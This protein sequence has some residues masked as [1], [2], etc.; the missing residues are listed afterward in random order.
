MHD[1]T[2][3]RIGSHWFKVGALVLLAVALD[4]VGPA[5]AADTQLTVDYSFERPQ[6]S[7]VT[8]GGEL[9]DRITMPGV[10]NCGNTGEPALPA[11][12]ARILLPLGTE[13]SGIELV[14]GEKVLLGTDYRIEPVARPVK[15]S[16][17][18]GS[19]TLPIPDPAIYASDQAFPGTW[20]K[21]IGTHGF[22]GYRILTLK[23]QPVQYVPKSGELCYYPRLT[24]VVSIADTGTSPSL[25]RG[26]AVD[27][28]EVL[29]KVDNI[30]IAGTYPLAGERG[31]S[32]SYDLLIITT[33]SL[34]SAFQ[35][36]KD[37]HDAHGI[38]TEIHTTTEIGGSDP[39]TVRDYITDRYNN[40]G[41]SYVI[42][43][44]DDDLIP[45]PDLYVEAWSGGDVESAMPGDIYFA[46]LDGTWNYDGDSSWGEPNDG[47]GGGDVD[48]VAEV[49]VGRAS[50]GNTTEI[51][52]FV[53]KTLWYLNGGHTQ[54]EKVLLVGE[55]LGFGGVSDYAAGMMEQLI[56][57]CSADGYTTVGIPSSLYTVDELFE[58][59]MSWSQADIINR[60]D[61]GVHI[62]NHLGHGS[63]D[64]AMK[65]YDSDISSLSNTD[66]CF[67]YS[68][69]CLAGHFDGTDCWAEYMNLKT[70]NG[71]YAVIMNAR[72]GWGSGYSTDGPNQR[73]NR[74]FWDAVFGEGKMELG[75][76]NHDSKEDNLYRVNQECM[77]WCYYEINL[78]GDPTVAVKGVDVP[79][80]ISF[81]SGLPGALTPGVP[82]N[83]SVQIDEGDESYVPGSGTLYYRYDGGTYLT[84]SLVHQSGDLYLA[85]LPSAGCD[86]TPEFYFSAEGS[87]SGVVYS[88][89]GGAGAPYTAGVGE[90]IIVFEDDCEADEGW[91]VTGDASD[92]QWD[93]GIPVDCDRGDPPT[94]YD[95][96]GQC[97]LTD[98]S[99]ADSCN[100]DVDG[101]YTYLSS[102]TF[103][104]SDGDA[105]ISYALWYTNDYG[106]DPDNDLFKV[107]VS[108][109]NGGSWTL[110]ETFGPASSSGWTEH[111]FNV[112]DFVTPTSQVKVRFEASDLNDGSVVE[113]GVDAISVAQ[114]SCQEGPTCSDG[115][116]NQDE[117]RIDC[118][119]PNCDP[120]ECT[121]DAACDNDVYCDGAET[122]DAYGHCQSG[123]DVDCDDSVTCTDDSCNEDTD[124]CDNVPNDA[125]CDDGLYCNGAE[126]CDPVLDCQPGSYACGDGAWCDEDEDQCVAYGDGDFEPNGN[127]DL[128]DFAA[129]QRCFG[130]SGI[131]NC[132]AGNMIGQDAMIDLSDY[133]EFEEALTG[134]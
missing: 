33:S 96:S 23:L 4:P 59:D 85:T 125:L 26:L 34:A 93:R 82:T 48:L 81:P 117:E 129:F 100:S 42:I 118:G 30:E 74:E 16:A 102:P 21:E 110:V 8:I 71:G 109:N 122:C 58:R 6:I 119:G 75:R 128:A 77:R 28:A 107:Y 131:G 73:F 105:E 18:P 92:G 121:S 84:S 40:D 9:Y 111:A 29:G 104:L 11:R 106:A 132:A 69:T 60:I 130:Q 66:L 89:S 98:N 63:P 68:Q 43:G 24:V 87:A 2:R 1:S 123:T 12:G 32:R 56:D 120:C 36:L 101:G 97:Y 67:V 41:I 72:Y 70:D 49:Y 45:A 116:Q 44:A 91:S 50:G 83:I 114:L 95:G 115:T 64:Y 39:S 99:A 37:Y 17:D 76:A 57:G 55:Y 124:S 35:P 20:F 7:K 61:A 3:R 126:T 113:A 25:F 5:W 53:D 14:P 127:V 27:E 51:T 19:V 65:L 54:I 103:D 133:A 112:S 62:L 94:D 80:T 108:N 38:P 79:L 22:R 46:C 88:P 90:L 78:F 31:D 52:R 15:L 47:P 10:P 86:D 134:P 13:V